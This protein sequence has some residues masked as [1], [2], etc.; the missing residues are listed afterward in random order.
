MRILLVDDDSLF[1]D[2]VSWVVTQDE[3]MAHTIR[4]DRVADGD[5]AL[6]FFAGPK[7]ETPSCWPDLVLLD[8]RMPRIDGTEVLRRLRR[9]PATRSLPICMLSS[10]G[11]PDLVDE[12]YAAG[13]NFYFVKPLELEDL[14]IKFR[15]IVDFMTNVAELPT[16]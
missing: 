1:F 16:A 2:L 7:H 3:S 13:A 15:K 11:Q 14:Q 9:A 5:E 10:S 8:Q 12:A 6:R 4:V